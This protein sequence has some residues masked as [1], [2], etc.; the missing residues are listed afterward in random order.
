MTATG[1]TGHGD[2]LSRK[3][4]DL[5]AALLTSPSVN[6]A[7]KTAGVSE[8]TARRWL[9]LP[10]FGASYRAARR[11]GVTHAVALLQRN[12]GA[13][14]AAILRN[15][16]EDQPPQIQLRAAELALKFSME[17]IEL[18]DLAARV[19]ELEE[20]LQMTDEGGRRHAA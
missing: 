17:G 14:V 12:A 15:L 2:K 1:S 11:E 7:A 13:A 19:A 6:A 20:R 3:Q 10:D 18:E 9:Q 8:S 4:E 5:L 16:K